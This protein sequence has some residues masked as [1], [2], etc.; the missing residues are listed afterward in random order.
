ME[1]GI[2]GLSENVIIFKGRQ[3]GK[4]LEGEGEVRK[5]TEGWV[6]GC[7]VDENNFK[8]LHSTWVEVHKFVQTNGGC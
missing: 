4:L 3:A 1:E 6:D 7:L 5:V 2:F 8:C